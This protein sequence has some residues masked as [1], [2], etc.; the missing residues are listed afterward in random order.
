MKHSSTFKHRKQKTRVKPILEQ[1]SLFKFVRDCW[2]MVFDFLIF[3]CVCVFYGFV[4][5]SLWPFLSSTSCP[6]VPHC[7]Q[8]N[9][10]LAIRS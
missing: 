3:V 9:D 8:L 5:N 6:S 10:I 1:Q 7:S 4:L 2:G